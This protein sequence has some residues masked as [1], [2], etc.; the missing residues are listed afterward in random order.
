MY[1]RQTLQNVNVTRNN[2]NFDLDGFLG[3]V[4]QLFIIEDAVKQDVEDAIETGLSAELGPAIE[5]ILS[6]FVISGNLFELLAVDVQVDAPITQVIHNSSG[7]TLLLDGQATVVSAEPGSPNVTTFRSTP[8]SPP[9]FG[10]TSPGGFGYGAGLAAADDFLNQVLAA[11]TGA[12]LLNGDLSSLLS[13]DPFGMGGMGSTGTMGEPLTTDALQLLF[14]G[15]GF[16]L[17]PG[18]TEVGLRAGGTMPPVARTNTG[19]GSLGLIELEDLVVSMEVPAAGGTIPVL[20]LTVDGSAEM[21]LD[22]DMEGTLVATLGNADVEVRV[23]QGFPGSDLTVLQGGLDFLTGLLL[24]ALTDVLGAIPIPSLEA[25]G[26]GVMAN[27][28]TTTGGQNEYLGFYGDLVFT[29]P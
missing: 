21:D 29:T 16:D 3:S 12:G 23:L 9:T 19:G 7:A 6:E 20:L 26:L 24:P 27:E 13:G 4:A 1:K 15:A 28:I 11:A 17:F 10:A 2:F 18:G 8:T 22:I 5:A 25:Q 14:P